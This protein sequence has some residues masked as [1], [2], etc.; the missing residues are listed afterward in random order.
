MFTNI[1]LFTFY[2]FATYTLNLFPQNLNCSNSHTSYTFLLYNTQG[3]T[4]LRL[5]KQAL[6][7]TFLQTL[8]F[9]YVKLPGKMVCVLI[10]LK[11]LAKKQKSSQ[12]HT[13]VEQVLQFLVKW[14]YLNDILTY[15]KAQWRYSHLV[16]VLIWYNYVY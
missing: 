14:Y 6:K 7:H 4:T 13:L 3:F 11:N 2:Q 16:Q 8:F 15:S 1:G 9:V 10:K 5:R 12:M